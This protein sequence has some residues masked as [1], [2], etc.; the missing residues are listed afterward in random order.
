MRAL[1][2]KQNIKS[3]TEPFYVNNI[4]FSRLLDNGSPGSFGCEQANPCKRQ[5]R[6][7]RRATGTGSGKAAS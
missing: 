5:S 1:E 4:I 7:S 6:S 2:A 3:I